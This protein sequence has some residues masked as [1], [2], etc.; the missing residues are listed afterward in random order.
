M[1]LLNEKQIEIIIAAEQL[2]AEEGFDGTSVRDIAKV[3][4]VNIAMI[5]YYF[6]SKEKL[7]ESLLLYRV[8]SMRLTLE[9]VSQENISP[10]EK[11]NK[12]IATYVKRIHANRCVYQII[13]FEL[14][15]KKREIN[16]KE[17]IQLKKE[18][19]G[20]IEAIVKEGQEKGIY[21]KNVNTPLLPSIIIGSY[22]HFQMNKVYYVDLLAL[23]T[24]EKYETYIMEVLTPHI[25]KTINA[26]LTYEK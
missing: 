11:M 24:E 15:N 6:G 22:V 4:N 3:A 5:S 12:L 23:D 8:N 7:L 13:H 10:V 21:S 16:F 25:Q 20:F 1:S 2:F 9:S 19:L 14:S 18:N 26:L 17:F